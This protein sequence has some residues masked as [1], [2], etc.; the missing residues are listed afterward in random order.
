MALRVN[1][2][3]VD[4][5]G[6]AYPQWRVA[7][8]ISGASTKSSLSPLYR[9]PVRTLGP[10]AEPPVDQKGETVRLNVGMSDGSIRPWLLSEAVTRGLRNSEAITLY[11]PASPEQ[12]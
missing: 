9:T 11:T 4:T 2:G 6:V 10:Q 8:P 1:V 12:P 5:Q 3:G 7:H